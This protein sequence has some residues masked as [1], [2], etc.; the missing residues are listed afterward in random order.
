MRLQEFFNTDFKDYSNSDNVRSIPSLIDGFKDSQRKAVY[1][2]Q[3][4]GSSEIRVS[5]LG[6]KSALLTHY[7]HGETSL[8]DTIVGLAQN[9]AGSNNVN[10]FEPIGQ[11]GSILTS[12]SGAHRYIYT[13]P[14]KWFDLMLRPIDRCILEHRYEDGDK[15]EPL[16][17]LPVIPLWAVNGAIGI[18][19]GHSVKIFPRSL[20]QVKKAIK[21]WIN[22][23]KPKNS[24]HPHFNGWKG[25][26]IVEGDGK[27]T[28]QGIIEKVNTTTLRITELPIT[29]DV[30]SFKAKVLVPLLDAGKIK[31]FENNSTEEN[32]FCF[33]VKVAREIG[34]KSEA[35][36]ITMFKLAKKVTENITLWS[37]DNQ[38]EQFPTF[39]DALYSA[40]MFRLSKYEESRKKQIADLS[41]EVDFL[42][43]K[44]KF[45]KAWNNIEAQA[46]TTAQIREHMVGSA[47][48]QPDNVDAFLKMPISSITE[49]RVDSLRKQIMSLEDKVADLNERTGTNLMEE[50]L[51]NL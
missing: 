2:M 8:C 23:Q 36:L 19:T 47:G 26:V 13:K 9:F 15:T 35:Q 24:L 43:E 29:Y 25:K 50:D 20:D 3:M 39:V 45:I 12:E 32:G 40:V 7:E 31:D 5:Q 44:L 21:H 34:K 48:L 51:A 16:Y 42:D 17:Y 18:G 41:A 14:S 4:H 37:A 11:F 49:D 28:F 38:L 30:D 10:L 46:L 1:G 6:A 33:D 22:G 27:Y